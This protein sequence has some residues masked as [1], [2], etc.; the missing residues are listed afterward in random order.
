MKEKFLVI[1]AGS[2]SLK[3]TLYNALDNTEIV[4]G[5]VEKIGEKGSSY[6]LKYNE[7]K[8]PDLYGLS[9]EQAKS[10]LAEYGLV[11]GNIYS[12]SGSTSKGTVIAQ[13]VLPESTINS[14]ITSIDIYVSS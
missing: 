13:S 14:S 3:F 2:S 9:I 12:V 7:K 8:M 11:V 10:K 5:I 6:T 4:N 1:N